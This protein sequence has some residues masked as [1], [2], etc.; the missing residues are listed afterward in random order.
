MRRS[1]VCKCLLK[2]KTEVYRLYKRV[3]SDQETGSRNKEGGVTS[4]E[5]A[6]VNFG[7]KWRLAYCYKERSMDPKISCVIYGII[8]GIIF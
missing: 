7:A 1:L 3:W 4:S 5:A 2:S 8:S 6:Q